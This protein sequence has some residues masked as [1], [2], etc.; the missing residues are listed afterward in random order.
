MVHGPLYEDGCLQG[1]LELAGIAYVGCPV[2]ASAIGMDKDIARRLV[3][4][5][6]IKTTRYHLLTSSQLESDIKSICQSI[7]AELNWPLFVKPC[8][9][10]SSVGIHK[11]NN[12]EELLTAI[13]NA[14]CYDEAILIEEYISGREIELAVLENNSTRLAPKVSK[15]GEI[16]VNHP[17]G[18]YSYA[19]KYLD[20]DATEL[21]IPAHLDSQLMARLKQAAAD[22]FVALKCRGMA[23]VDFFVDEKK[24]EFYFSE[25]NTI[26]GFTPIS[27]YPKMWERSGLAYVDLLDQLIL[28]ALNHRK[29]RD[30]L[31]THYQ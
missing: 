26:P 5:E 4:L 24:D 19:A 11:V 10:G 27:M 22:I 29:N 25:I 16:K 20:S 8:S 23:R 12:M 3:R 21:V 13:S 14:K 1:L 6:G 9:M 15:P 28:L 31:I 7:I 30:Q 2:L 17:D 18:F